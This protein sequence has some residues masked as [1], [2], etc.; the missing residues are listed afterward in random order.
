MHAVSAAGGVV[1]EYV[2]AGQTVQSATPSWYEACVVS[3]VLPASVPTGQLVHAA[4]A[5]E[6]EKVPMAQTL[7]SA[8][9]SCCEAAVPASLRYVPAGQAR[10]QEP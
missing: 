2:S 3:A 5:E 9:L 1:V 4:A 10:Q 8:M 7:Q 6:V